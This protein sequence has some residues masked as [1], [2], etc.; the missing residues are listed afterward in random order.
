MNVRQLVKND[1]TAL[2][3]FALDRIQK[4]GGVAWVVDDENV[5]QAI[6]LLSENFDYE[7]AFDRDIA[8]A[9]MEEP[10]LQALYRWRSKLEVMEFNQ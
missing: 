8:N 5:D 1:P 2:Q 10:K 7:G 9:L 3:A 4:S 6:A